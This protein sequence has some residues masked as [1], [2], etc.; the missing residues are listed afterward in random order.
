MGGIKAMI[1]LVLQQSKTALIVFFLS[2]TVLEQCNAKSVEYSFNYNLT[3]P[4]ARLPPLSLVNDNKLYLEAF[5][6][7]HTHKHKHTLASGH[8]NEVHLCAPGN[9]INQIILCKTQ[10]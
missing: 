1:S 7:A 3:E 6:S 5:D 8:P 10:L 9:L 2:P 4:L